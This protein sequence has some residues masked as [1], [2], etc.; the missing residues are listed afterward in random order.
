MSVALAVPM[1]T[2]VLTP[3]ASIV[4]SAGGV[5]TGG[6]VSLTVMI[7]WAVVL[8]L[9]ESM[10]VQV[11]WVVPGLKPVGASLFTV[12]GKRSVAVPFPMSTA[13][14]APVASTVLSAGTVNTGGVVSVIVIFWIPVAFWLFASVAVQVT[15]VVPMG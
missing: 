11:T 8:L 6:V 9:L 14:R 13:V 4:I 3:V 2:T 10:A 7:C 5:K 12:T 1:L 15:E